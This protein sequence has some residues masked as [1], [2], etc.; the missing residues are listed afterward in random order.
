[1]Q[2]ELLLHAYLMRLV[3]TPTALAEFVRDDLRVIYLRWPRS[4]NF[5]MESICALVVENAAQSNP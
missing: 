5:L 2:R 1:M 4:L 3:A